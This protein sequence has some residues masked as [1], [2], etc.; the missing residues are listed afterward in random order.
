[1][2]EAN[3]AVLP[4]NLMVGKREILNTYELCEEYPMFK[5]DNLLKMVRLKLIPHFRIGRLVYFTRKAID[6][7]IED[8]Q[9]QSV[10]IESGLR[11][12]R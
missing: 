12:V 3:P 1:M 7:W 8:Q 4:E 2:P 10:Q 6:Q 9:K 11:M 5:Y